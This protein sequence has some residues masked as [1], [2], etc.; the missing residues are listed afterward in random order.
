MGV[1]YAFVRWCSMIA[2]AI[3]MLAG[4]LEHDENNDFSRVETESHH[5]SIGGFGLDLW[6]RQKR[7]WRAPRANLFAVP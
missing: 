2:M 4:R 6:I 3:E 1:I 5:P 7:M